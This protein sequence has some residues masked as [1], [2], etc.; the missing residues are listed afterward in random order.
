MGIF[1]QSWSLIQENNNDNA[2]LRESD[3][4]YSRKRSTFRWANKSI[5]EDQ[6]TTFFRDTT[7]ELPTTILLIRFEFV[8]ST[9]HVILKQKIDHADV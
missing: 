5:I 9:H 3:V 7:F 8:L 6:T 2:L 1:Y 4:L